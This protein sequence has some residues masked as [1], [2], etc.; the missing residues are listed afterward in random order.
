M[1]SFVCRER[2]LRRAGRGELSS[3]AGMCGLGPQGLVWTYFLGAND[4]QTACDGIET[5]RVVLEAVNR[6]VGEG[7]DE[8]EGQW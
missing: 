2:R 7:S 4:V 3:E 1:M 8:R 6:S 5:L